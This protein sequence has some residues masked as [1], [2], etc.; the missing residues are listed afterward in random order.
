MKLALGA[1]AIVVGIG[2]AFAS[3]RIA[4]S[5]TG[6]ALPEGPDAV[7]GVLAEG[8][9]HESPAGDAFLYGEVKLARPGS[10]AMEQ[11]WS[12]TFGTRQLKITTEEG[13]V[14]LGFPPP[15][16]WRGNLSVD[17][18]ENV[19][20]LST[21]PVLSEIE[22]EARQRMS[23][24]YVVMVRAVRPGDHVV[25]LRDG[26][27][28]RDVYVGEP[29]EL[30]EWIQRRESERWPVVVLLGVMGLASIGLGVRASR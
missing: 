30:S 19:E 22:E 8:E 4:V 17:S 2:F 25:G 6:V 20:D 13:E 28:L 5:G 27:E 3:V 11:S 18:L 15:D 14:T 24:P 12:N 26:D 9:T 7:T 16:S 10:R 29:A 23:P 1:L 21:L